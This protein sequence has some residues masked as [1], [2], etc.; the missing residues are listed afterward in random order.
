VTHLSL[1][2]LHTPATESANIPLVG[3][4][5]TYIPMSNKPHRPM[6]TTTPS[7]KHAPSR[8]VDQWNEKKMLVGERKDD[9]DK[10]FCFRYEKNRLVI[11]CMGT[12]VYFSKTNRSAT[13]VDSREPKKR[14][15][16]DEI[17]AEIYR[18]L[19]DSAETD[20]AML[21]LEFGR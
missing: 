4:S 1:P 9:D 3:L 10:P 16:R 20:K 11:E 15:T 21:A 5:M 17:R 8:V 14:F 12:S 13:F 7:V 2:V 19:G 6:P 18:M